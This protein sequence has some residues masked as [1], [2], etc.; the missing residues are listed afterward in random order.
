MKKAFVLRS[1][2]TGLYF[3]D[4]HPEKNFV[5]GLGYARKFTDVD[6]IDYLLDSVNK[7]HGAHMLDTF[8]FHKPLEVVTIY[9]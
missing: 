9:W 1:A 7:E 3:S 8:N 6:E 5:S 4:S 2:P